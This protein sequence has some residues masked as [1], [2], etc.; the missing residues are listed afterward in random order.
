MKAG[1]D[2]QQM[3][4]KFEMR[5]S[6]GKYGFDVA[7]RKRDLWLV[8]DELGL[9]G[10]VDY[11]LETEDEAAIVDFKLTAGEPGENHRL[12]LAGY[13][14]L[15]ERRLGKPVRRCFIYRIPDDRI[16][17]VEID[18][19]LRAWRRSAL[20]QIEALDELP[21]ATEVRGRCKDC[22]YLNFCGDIW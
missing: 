12:Q 14:W 21:E 9:N 6:L 22:E 8:D 11:L 7:Q 16:F 1:I 18:E 13:A 17:P 15:V 2:A 10:R 20:E 3:I 19:R 4:E 5:R